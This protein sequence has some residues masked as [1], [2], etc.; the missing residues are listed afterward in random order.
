MN[1]MSTNWGVFNS[2]DSQSH[3]T[4]G[5]PNNGRET[6]A[7][8]PPLA[9]G[10]SLDGG[11][12]DYSETFLISPAIDLTGF[13]SATLHFWHSYDFT[14]RS[15]FDIIEG[16]QLLLFTNNNASA[17]PI[18]TYQSDATSGWEE[19][20]VDLSPYTGSVIYLVW[21]YQL[22]SFDSLPRP[23]WLVDD[24]SISAGLVQSGRVTI[25]NNIMEPAFALTGPV[26][27][28]G[29]GQVAVYSNSPPGQYVVTFGPVT[30]FNTPPPQTNVLVAG[31]SIVFNGN[32][33]ITDANSNGIPD[34]W[35]AS[36]GLSNP[37]PATDTDHDGIPDGVEFIAG[38]NPTNA[39]SKLTLT[40]PTTPTNGQVQLSWPSV[41]G[42]FYRLESST[43]LGTWT[44]VA[45]WVA[46][47]GSTQTQLLPAATNGPAF[48]R[49]QVQP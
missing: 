47:N 14:E 41:S 33:T 8:S 12:L 17:I 3:W 2:D 38:T 10:C 29:A 35:E 1:G 36:Y 46:G 23:G 18:A 24:V 7:H 13:N 39:L 22:F 34:T 48:Y 37:G 31:G 11:A 21:G 43:N 32:Y 6:S 44:P 19:A 25:T 16:G 42:R 28:N 49:V 5:V 9:W 30:F 26:S 27:H 20:T 4:L 15:E 45:G 40:P